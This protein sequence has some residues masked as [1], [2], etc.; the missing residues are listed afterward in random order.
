MA[1]GGDGA[2]TPSLNK[3]C[4][5]QVTRR[6]G[7]ANW[8]GDSH[9]SHAATPPLPIVSEIVTFSIIISLAKILIL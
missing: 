2:V 4:T 7:Y 8:V 3:I 5:S 6:L 9:V 1:A